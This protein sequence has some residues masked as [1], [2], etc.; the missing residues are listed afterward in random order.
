[1]FTN[2]L[3][4]K[5]CFV[6]S[7]LAVCCAIASGAAALAADTASNDADV[8]QLA[9]ARQMVQGVLN[10][11]DFKTWNQLLADDVVFNVRLGT[12]TKDSAGD[13]ALV[14]MNVEFK[15]R[16]AAKKAL[17]D[18]YGDLHKDFRVT[19]EINHGAEVV[20]MGE[21][22][23]ES[24]GKDPATLPIAVYMAFNPAGKIERIGIF[25]VDV[26]ALVAALQPATS[27]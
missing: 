7:A 13:P 5:S 20:F 11:R 22:V 23:V 3:E 9:Q 21:L 27:G 8:N 15:G 2:S 18:I 25:S 14:G 4:R 19:T 24:K 12:A 6:A 10:H 16:D 17:R 26:R 1:M